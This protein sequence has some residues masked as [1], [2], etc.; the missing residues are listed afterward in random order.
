MT[1]SK[2]SYFYVLLCKDGTLYGGYTTEL[3]RRIEEHNAGTGAKYTRIQARRPVKM[4][5]AEMYATRSEATRAE[6]AF[7]RLSRQEKEQYLKK[8]GVA[9]PLNKQENCVVV[10]QT[11]NQERE[12]RVLDEDTAK[13]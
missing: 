9:F 11:P 5:Y 3:Q 2:Q 8:Q 1:K 12:E 7:K 6:A 4:I 13:L 10:E